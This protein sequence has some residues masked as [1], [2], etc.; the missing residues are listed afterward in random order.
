MYVST[1]VHLAIATD[2]PAGI[3]ADARRSRRCDAIETSITRK[4]RYSRS[5]VAASESGQRSN[6]FVIGPAAQISRAFADSRATS[7]SE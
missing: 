4:I 2:D 3:R 7:W 6:I 5:G 1:D